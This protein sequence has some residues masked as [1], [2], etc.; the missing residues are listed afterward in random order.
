LNA[1]F[2]EDWIDDVGA[3]EVV[4]DDGSALGGD[5]AGESATEGDA[6]ASFDLLLETDGR[7]GDQ[8]TSLLVEQQHGA[9]VRAEDG[10]NSRQQHLEQLIER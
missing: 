7:P 9:C 2:A 10:A 5:T 3:L 4:E 1:S 6:D 8:F